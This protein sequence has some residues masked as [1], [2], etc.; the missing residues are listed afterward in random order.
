MIRYSNRIRRMSRR[1]QKI[2]LQRA[3]VAAVRDRMKERLVERFAGQA[4]SD[5]IRGQVR[6]EVVAVL[7]SFD[8]WPVHTEVEGDVLHVTVSA[9]PVVIQRLLSITFKSA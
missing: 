3:A 6:D 7:D 4:F 2:A 5:E 1:R 8:H 9:P